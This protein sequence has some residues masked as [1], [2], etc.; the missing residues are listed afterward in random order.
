MKQYI[1]TVL[2]KD[3]PYPKLVCYDIFTPHLIRHTSKL[4]PTIRR[5]T[6]ISVLPI[7]SPPLPLLN[8]G[9]IVHLLIPWQLTGAP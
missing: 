4:H 6:P 3:H 5:K 7:A 8:R 9:I 1:N 2:S